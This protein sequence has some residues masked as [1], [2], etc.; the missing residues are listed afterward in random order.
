MLKTAI[1]NLVEELG[2]PQRETMLILDRFS[3]TGKV[4]SECNM[5]QEME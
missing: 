2:K 1:F 5:A 4:K 3:A